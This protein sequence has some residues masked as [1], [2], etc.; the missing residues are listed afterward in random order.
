MT[1]LEALFRYAEPP[2]PQVALALAR[3][4]DVYGVHRL[5]WNHE[6]RT[7]RVE[8]DSTRL[9]AATVAKLLLAAG[10]ELVEEISLV[11]EAV[12]EPAPA[13]F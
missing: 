9:N 3:T 10:L 1:R 2:A 13:S 12:A 8:F 5:I 4:R 6:A 11:P 7:L